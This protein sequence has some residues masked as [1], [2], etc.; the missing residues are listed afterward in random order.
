MDSAIKT[1][2]GL[3]ASTPTTRLQSVS[4]SVAQ[5]INTALFWNRTRDM[6]KGFINASNVNFNLSRDT[7]LG[8]FDTYL[9]GGIGQVESEHTSQKTP[10]SEY[11]YGKVK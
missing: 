2:R 3:R 4:S 7:R 11:F 5:A 9:C 6:N 1:P 8:L 10:I